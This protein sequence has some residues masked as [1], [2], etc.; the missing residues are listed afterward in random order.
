MH[1]CAVWVFVWHILG[2]SVFKDIASRT[3]FDLWIC[4]KCLRC[5]L[6]KWC[7]PGVSPCST[8]AFLAAAHFCTL[9]A[10]R[11]ILFL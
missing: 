10:A 4:I 1:A 11:Q 9:S 5:S 2:I 6:S 7:G 8:K 3:A